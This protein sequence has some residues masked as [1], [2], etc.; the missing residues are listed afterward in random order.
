M[1]F[2]SGPVPADLFQIKLFLIMS[3]IDKVYNAI[4]I[5]VVVA[6]VIVVA[7]ESFTGLLLSGSKSAK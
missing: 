2:I 4:I 5:V 6:I 1:I 3:I 7:A